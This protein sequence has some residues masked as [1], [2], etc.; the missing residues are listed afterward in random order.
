MNG[1]E[2]VTIETAIKEAASIAFAGIRALNDYLCYMLICL[3]VYSGGSETVSVALVY[4]S[5]S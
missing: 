2:N 1:S 4:I 3:I 5:T